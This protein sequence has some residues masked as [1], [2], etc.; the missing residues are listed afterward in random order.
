MTEPKSL[1]LSALFSLCMLVGCA[2]PHFFP[3]TRPLFAG[4]DETHV[5]A[6]ATTMLA[7]AKVDFQLARQGHAPQHAKYAQTIPF[8]RSKVY[9]GQGYRLTVV[10]EDI[11]Y[12]HKKGPD[13]VLS[14][15]ITGG[16]PY[17]YG[18][19]DEVTY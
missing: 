10:H 18:E 1:L 3:R 14:S 8:T 19:V 16:K 13:I 5:P 2:N 17:H 7:Q 6:G 12:P 15:T 11:K 4:L 9:E